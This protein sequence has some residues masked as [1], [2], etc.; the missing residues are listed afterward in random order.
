MS[1][2]VSPG[3]Q[4]NE[5]DLT[6]VVA[7]VATT[8]GAIGGVFRWGQV[9]T[10]IQV[11]SETDY[12]TQVGKP[13][14]FNAETW[15]VGADFLSFGGTLNVVRGANTTGFSNT[16]TVT[17]STNTTGSIASPNTGLSN[18]LLV[19]GPGVQTGT[20]TTNVSSNS[21]VTT[22][23]LSKAT[24]NAAPGT[25]LFYSPN[26]VFTAIANSS[27]I[28]KSLSTYVV[29][30][31]DLYPVAAPNFEV[32][33]VNYVAKWPGAMGSSLQ[34]SVCGSSNQYSTNVNLLNY[35]GSTF[36]NNVNT[37]LS[38]STGT[39]FATVTVANTAG[40]NDMNTT[41]LAGNV[42]SIISPGDYLLV[43]NTT[44]GTSY[45]QVNA[46]SAVVTGNVTVNAVSTN[47]GTASFT[48][49]FNSPYVLSSNIA[50]SSFTRNWQY[51]NNVSG[52]P[53][54]SAYQAASG[55]TA[56]NDQMHVVVVDQDGL[57]TG[58]P[59]QI[60]ETWANLS[61]AT[62][63]KNP[64]GTG[65]YY[66]DV[67]NNQSSYVWFGT[68]RNGAAS[69]TS[70]NLTSSTNQTP[71]TLS[72]VAGSDGDDE[73]T[74]SFGTIASA[75]DKF[76]SAENIDIGL[77]MTGKSVGGV[78]GEQA[79]NYIVDNVISKRLDCVAFT[80]APSNTVVQAYGALPGTQ[81]TNVVA[82][83]NALRPSSYLVVDTGYYYRYDKYN[84][85]YRWIPL[86]GNV[87][88]AC[89]YTDQVRDP[90][91]SPGGFARG[92]MKN[93]VKLAWNPKK[94]DRDILYPAGINPVVSFKGQGTVLYGDK[95][96]LIG[97]TSA[98]SR[99]G[100]RRLFIVLEKSISNASQFLLFEFND[101]FTQTQFTSVVNPYL[102]DV[103]G[104][105]G[106]TDFYIDL[107]GNTPQVVDTEQFIGNIYIK[108]NRS[109]NYITLNFIATPSGVSFNEII[110]ATP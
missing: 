101:I 59:G 20:V 28:A 7:S 30:K 22:F 100:V 84:D 69:N 48:I 57:F 103:K 105:R 60:L 38:I 85:T 74:V 78:Y 16:A 21:T 65:N 50:M 62:D 81:L 68:D 102:R 107:S 70:L 4:I 14:N 19:F 9:G 96:H 95:T 6:T 15:F 63:N 64:N 46:V 76:A 83:G 98:F 71:L 34:V 97:D 82:W 72:F 79:A 27:P 108:P 49:T 99:I 17:L 55:N 5:I 33:V 18:N 41:Q 13:T 11:S 91:Y 40:A 66:A 88:G 67:L 10:P 106:V 1:F 52:A 61:R 23:N 12:V 31:R 39:N 56:A 75:Y 77:I 109:I 44:I 110:G 25:L 37:A 53:G 42:A 51:F 35:N 3:S 43:G 80:S 24:T 47:T 87:A 2:Q 45:L 36:G 32:G 92:Q 90:W 58:T 8:A 86:N 89:V 104:R 29:S 93:I 26:T 73:S 54:Q 94:E